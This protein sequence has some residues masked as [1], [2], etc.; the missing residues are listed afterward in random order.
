[1]SWYPQSISFRKTCTF[2]EK[3]L[4]KKCLNI[5]FRS[6]QYINGEEWNS[7]G[8]LL[9]LK[10]REKYI[11]FKKCS[12]MFWLFEGALSMECCYECPFSST[13]RCSDITLGDFW[14]IEKFYPEFND[15]DGVSMLLI[16][17]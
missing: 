4:Q 1:M 8:I 17:T 14:G 12:Y 16:N 5:M 7:Y 13:S 9:Q 15:V 3:T 10:D 11:P 2:R 6:K